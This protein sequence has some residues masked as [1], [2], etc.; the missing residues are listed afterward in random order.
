MQLAGEF[1]FQVPCSLLLDLQPEDAG[2]ERLLDLFG[3]RT[4]DD[5]SRDFDGSRN[6]HTGG[7]G[8]GGGTAGTRHADVPGRARRADDEQAGAASL[9]DVDLVTIL[10]RRFCAFFGS[11]SLLKKHPKTNVIGIIVL[12]GNTLCNIFSVGKSSPTNGVFE[13][14]SFR[15]TRSE[16]AL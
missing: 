2:S 8:S 1:F 12:A 3:G 15:S 5:G 11:T 4:V 6:R 14:P 10:S 13:N 9:P 7:A 16:T